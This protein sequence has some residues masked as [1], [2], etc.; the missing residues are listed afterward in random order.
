MA[1]PPSAARRRNARIRREEARARIAAAA[2]RL[3]ADRPY[4][5]LSVDAVMAE[6]GLSRTVFYRHYDG[7]PELVLELFAGVAD[8]LAAELEV[9][10]PREVLEAAASAF[11]AH[12][13]LLRALDQAA[14]HDALIERTY[15]EVSDRFT[16]RMA[17]QLQE[18]MDE[19]RVR[20]G[21][22]HELA[23]ALNLMNQ[24][25]LLETVARDPDFGRDR[26]VAA[27]LA[28]WEPVTGGG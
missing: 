12:G 24:R 14:G 17:E 10:E 16:A 28:V 23:R 8:E 26:A 27:L 6:A 7:L 2:E 15:R 4:R 22:P 21:D 5:E 9:G 20:P 1:S 13:P 25:Y 19:G 3:L 18:G 11:A